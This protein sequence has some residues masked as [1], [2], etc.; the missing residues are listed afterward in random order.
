MCLMICDSMELR[1]ETNFDDGVVSKLHLLL[2]LD[3]VNVDHRVG[4]WLVEE[5]LM[6]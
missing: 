2:F 4:Q 5:I 1:C 6:V 3:M